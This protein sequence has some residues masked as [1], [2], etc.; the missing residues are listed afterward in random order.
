MADLPLV[1]GHTYSET[2]FNNLITSLN[3]TK[4]GAFSY[5]YVSTPVTT[6]ITDADTYYEV[7]G[8]YTCR[9]E[10]NF[11]ATETYLRCNK[12]GK[13][14]MPISISFQA[15]KISDN[16]FAVLKNDV[17]IAG[18]EIERKISSIGGAGAL[19]LFVAETFEVNDQI[20]IVTK[21][22]QANQETSAI[23]IQAFI[24]KIID[25]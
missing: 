17:L 10:E 12:A 19:A 16:T 23:Y 18:S 13:Y 14:F 21:S 20:K 1:S 3:T 2:D 9:Y 24:N 15:N 11:T 7:E 22:S 6:I 25:Y 5:C 8:V 4:E